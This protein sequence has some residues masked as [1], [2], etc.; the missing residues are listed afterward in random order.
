[1]ASVNTSLNPTGHPGA[2]ADADDAWL[3]LP[4]PRSR[5]PLS[6]LSRT[7]LTELV[8]PCARNSF[9]PPVEA[10]VLKRKGARR[11]IV[12][13]RRASLLAYLADLPAPTRTEKPAPSSLVSPMPSG[14]TAETDDMR[15]EVPRGSRA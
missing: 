3:R 12:L 7:T 4:S 13:I 11:G 14:T 8:M 9:R 15:Q 2:G 6:G 1:M 5:C 10:R